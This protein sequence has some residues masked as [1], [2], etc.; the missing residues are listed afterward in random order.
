MNLFTARLLMPT[1]R[2]HDY[3]QDRLS[4]LPDTLYQRD[5]PDQK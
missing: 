2:R 1:R 5:I 3:E 4:Y